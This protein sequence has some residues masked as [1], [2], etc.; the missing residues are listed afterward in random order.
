MV[1]SETPERVDGSVSGPREIQLDEEV[2]DVVQLA[3]TQAPETVPNA[4]LMPRSTA[5]P[6]PTSEITADLLGTDMSVQRLVQKA[7]NSAGK[8]VNLLAKHFPS[9]RDETRF[10]G[11]RIRLLKRAQIFVADVWAA[12]NGTR[13]GAFT[14]IDHLTMFA[15]ESVFKR[16]DCMFLLTLAVEKVL[17]RRSCI[18]DAVEREAVFFA[19]ILRVGDLNGIGS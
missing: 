17:L 9:F 4:Q 2:R 16:L 11:R 12:F 6:G 3:P 5:Q 15:G 19:C 7:G 13:C 1:T 18:V 8:L 14:D 10:E